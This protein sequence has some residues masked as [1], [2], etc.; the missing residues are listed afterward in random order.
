MARKYEAVGI[1]AVTIEDKRFPK[2]NS[3]TEKC[4]Q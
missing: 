2:V 1:A 3:I 4:R